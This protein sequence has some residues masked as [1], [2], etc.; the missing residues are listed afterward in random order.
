MRIRSTRP[1]FWRSKTIDRLP[2][3]ERLL[4]RGHLPRMVYGGEI[5]T[6]QQWRELEQGARLPRGTYASYIYHLF[7]TAGDA[8]YFGKATYPSRRLV[9][10]RRK[11]WWPEVSLLNLYVISCDGHPDDPCRGWGSQPRHVIERATLLWE[12]KSIADVQPR[13]NIAA[14]PGAVA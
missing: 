4:M 11:P 7:D 12:S 13:Y 6:P 14:N 3:S 1:E 5:G 8:V 10:H 2:T 9:T